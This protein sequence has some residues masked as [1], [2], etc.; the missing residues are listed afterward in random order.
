MT[1]GDRGSKPW[2]GGQFSKGR[3]E[4]QKKWS[5][6]GGRFFK[7]RGEGQ[8]NWSWGGETRK[9]PDIF[10]PNMHFLT[11]FSNLLTII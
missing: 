7:G 5:W 1:I 2:E 11:L 9:K 4:G 8:K 10:G 6:E 3:G